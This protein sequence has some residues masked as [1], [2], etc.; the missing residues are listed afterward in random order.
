VLYGSAAMLMRCGVAL[1]GGVRPYGEGAC[2]D[3]WTGLLS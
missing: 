3:G 1:A 2:D